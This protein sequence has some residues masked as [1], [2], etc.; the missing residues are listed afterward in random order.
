MNT[1]SEGKEIRRPLPSFALLL[2]FII[3]ILRS[4]VTNF[5]EKLFVFFLIAHEKSFIFKGR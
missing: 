1:S 4:D 2:G 5:Y 3:P